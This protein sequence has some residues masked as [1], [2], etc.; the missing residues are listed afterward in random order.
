VVLGVLGGRTV[1]VAALELRLQLLQADV[2][3]AQVRARAPP[4]GVVV[5]AETQGVQAE[6]EAAETAFA[7]GGV[8]P[9]RRP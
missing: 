9:F 6:V 7:N 8:Q 5:R 1:L 2:G 3:Q 4:H